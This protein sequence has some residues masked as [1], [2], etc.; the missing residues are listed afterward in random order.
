MSLPLESPP[1]YLTHRPSQRE[2]RIRFAS[3]ASL[4]AGL[5]RAQREPWV[6]ECRAD[7]T[8]Q[9]LWV[10]MTGGQGFG[11]AGSAPCIRSRPWMKRAARLPM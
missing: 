6:E 3:R 1:A 5:A 9:E 7:L 8:Q 2:T 4:L 11:V 10:R